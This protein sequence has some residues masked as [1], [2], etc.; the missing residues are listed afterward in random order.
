[1]GILDLDVIKEFIRLCEDGWKLG[2][3]EYHGGNVTYRMKPEEVKEV[4]NFDKTGCGVD[5]DGR[6]TYQS[7]RRIFSG[8]GRW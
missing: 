2:Y 3:H 1:M 4:Q 6:K 8:K 7:C 5:R